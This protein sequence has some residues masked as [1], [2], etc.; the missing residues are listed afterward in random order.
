VCAQNE[1][2]KNRP[3]KKRAVK[4]KVPG[5]EKDRKLLQSEREKYLAWDL[6]LEAILVQEP[7]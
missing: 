4:F 5:V 1:T 3:V 2:L 7:P 6:F